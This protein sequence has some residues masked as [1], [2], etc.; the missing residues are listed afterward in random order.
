M[1]FVSDLRWAEVLSSIVFGTLGLIM[2]AVAY[3]AIELFTPYSLQE[4]LRDKQ[5]VALAVVVGSVLIALA[6]ILSAAI[7]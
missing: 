2:F 4:E 7:D 5:N 1:E 6:I 3:W